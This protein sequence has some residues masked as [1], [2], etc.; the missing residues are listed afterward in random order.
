MKGVVVSNVVMSLSV[1]LFHV[2]DVAGRVVVHL[3]KTKLEKRVNISS[4]G[5]R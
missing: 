3:S 5:Q 1:R 2:A 4:I